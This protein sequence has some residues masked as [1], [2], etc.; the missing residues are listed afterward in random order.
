MMLNKKLF[1]LVSL[2][3]VIFLSTFPDIKFSHSINTNSL[4]NGD[5]DWLR[6]TPLSIDGNWSLVQSEPWCSG[7][8]T[9][10]DPYIISYL[11]IDLN[12]T[13]SYR[14]SPCLEIKNSIK[15]FI[16]YRCTFLRAGCYFI[17]EYGSPGIYTG[18]GIRLDNTEYGL[19]SFCEF[20]DQPYSFGISLGHTNEV[21]VKNN[22][23]LDCANG[24]SIRYSSYCNITGNIFTNNSRC[25]REESNT[26]IIFKFNKCI[27]E[28]DPAGKD[29]ISGY[30]LYTFLFVFFMLNIIILNRSKKR[31]MQRE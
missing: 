7:S 9:L 30:W 1:Y 18:Y 13:K 4:N 23:F 24:L 29:I 6:S 20:S 22:T 28:R 19:I 27:G 3:F 5:G 10:N 16:I 17:D 21:H 25:I 31:I 2:V 11:T 26:E 15:H 14:S 12:F 8:G